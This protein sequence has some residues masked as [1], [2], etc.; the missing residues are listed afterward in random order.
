MQVHIATWAR[1][2]YRKAS[3]RGSR[4]PWILRERS[5]RIASLSLVLL[6]LSF[7]SAA[8]AQRPAP[9]H[10][11]QKPT[12]RPTAPA[13]RAPQAKPKESQPQI[14]TVK[15][16]DGSIWQAGY[17]AMIRLI[18]A[19]EL[20]IA[21]LAHNIGVGCLASDPSVY[22]QV[23]LPAY[24]PAP[25][26]AGPEREVPEGRT[27]ADLCFDARPNLAITAY[28]IWSGTLSSRDAESIKEALNYLAKVTPNSPESKAQLS[29]DPLRPAAGRIFLD[30]DTGEWNVSKKDDQPN[31][32]DLYLT[33]PQSPK[34]EI[35]LILGEGDCTSLPF[36]K[37]TQSNRERFPWTPFLY[38]QILKDGNVS[39]CDHFDQTS[40]VAIMNLAQQP[41]GSF[42]KDDSS[43]VMQML[44]RIEDALRGPSIAPA[45]MLKTHTGIPSAV[46]SP[47]SQ[48]IATFSSDGSSKVWD[49][50]NG[51]L[52]YTFENGFNDAYNQ[53]ISPD[54]RMILTEGGAGVSFWSLR[55]A[56]GGLPLP[57]VQDEIVEAISPD[58]RRFLTLHLPSNDLRVRNLDDGRLLAVLHGHTDFVSSAEFSPDGQRILTSSLDGTTRIWSAVEGSQIL[59]LPGRN[60]G[61]SWSGEG[62]AVNWAG[63]SPDGNRVLTVYL[64]RGAQLWNAEN[65]QLLRTFE[66]ATSARFS[67]DGQQILARD[68]ATVNIWNA[69]NV[70]L[71]LFLL[72]PEQQYL[73]ENH[74]LT[75]AEYSKNGQLILTLSRG[76]VPRI[77]NA[78]SGQLLATL[79]GHG[80]TVRDAMLSPDG[81]HV[82][83]ID[84]DGL[85]WLWRAPS[86]EFLGRL[87]GRFWESGW[88]GFS[89][90][91]KMIIGYSLDSE[92]VN[93]WQLG[94][95]PLQ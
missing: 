16:P 54:G 95:V 31:Q 43:R 82:L 10:S 78:S 42:S 4:H 14:E 25:F 51:Q 21:W 91:G 5:H 35:G 34:L 40:V 23:N 55:N 94:N 66:G 46:F 30:E 57:T 9:I 60:S 27:M 79:S 71:M 29:L 87:Q 63:F 65:G 81:Q 67:P 85:G 88:S 53:L 37:V 62:G 12:A 32:V 44:L 58:S 20:R 86:G 52:K 28:P 61:I 13:H 80:R 24:V 18:P 22:G 72:E 89:P 1:I 11:A 17:Q 3:R 56:S 59:I 92:S 74:K 49:A 41:D 50:S 15:L 36:E 73:D 6:A 69:A 47:N 19:P 77:W 70:R 7:A 33:W 76:K 8:G 2:H 48:E 38:A 93:V 83:T 68:I 39:T 26:H 90:D 84:E 75:R 64:N 45:F